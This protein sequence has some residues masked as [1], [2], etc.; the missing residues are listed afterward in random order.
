MFSAGRSVMR[1]FLT[2]KWSVV[3]AIP[4]RSVQRHPVTANTGV[5]V[6][7]PGKKKEVTRESKKSLGIRIIDT[8]VDKK[9]PRKE[10]MM[11]NMFMCRVDTDLLVY[12]EVFNYQDHPDVMEKVTP[13]RQSLDSIQDFARIDADDTIPETVWR[14]MGDL[15][16]FGLNIPQH[17][18]GLEYMVTDSLLVCESLAGEPALMAALG[19][20]L[21]VA[22]AIFRLGSADVK[23]IYLPR[24]ASGELT[25]SV[26]IQEGKEPESGLFNT[27]ATANTERTTW[28]ISGEKMFV[29]NGMKS[30]LLAVFAKT[31]HINYK[32][33]MDEKIS[34]FLVETDRTGVE[35]IPKSAPTLGYRGLDSITVKFNEVEVPSGNILGHVNEGETVGEVMLR[36]NRLHGGLTALGMI[37]RVLPE[38]AENCISRKHGDFKLIDLDMLQN[39]FSRILCNAYAIE[40]MIYMT[41]GLMDMYEDQDV[42]LECGV[43]KNFSSTALIDSIS[44]LSRHRNPTIFTPGHETERFMRDSLQFQVQNDVLDSLQCLIA[45]TGLQFMGKEMFEQVKKSRNP[46]FNPSFVLKKMF[47]AISFDNPKKFANL[48]HYLHLTAKPAADALEFSIVRLHLLSEFLLNQHGMEIIQHQVDLLRLSEVATLCYAMFASVARASRSYCIGLRHADYELHLATSVCSHA[49]ERIMK[50]AHDMQKNQILSH[51]T[52]HRLIGKQFFKSRGYFSE[53]PTARNF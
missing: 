45:L 19:S 21:Q 2:K 26:A 3:S 27:L 43:L 33:E 42:T 46:L 49:S 30:N 12:P 10:P 38:H 13:I 18:G 32:G 47:T 23:Q 7:E 48:E 51:D 17:F 34:V 24:L 8:K 15:G 28:K 53:N 4:I 11:K 29:A 22:D 25:A 39:R 1:K 37:R 16:L 52:A 9:L 40:S 14:K 5:P 31:E 20:H 36:L 6:E 50:L 35:K 44:R 41:A